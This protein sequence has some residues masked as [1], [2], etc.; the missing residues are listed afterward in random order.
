MSRAIVANF[1]VD[2]DYS[3]DMLREP[4][5]AEY[6]LRMFPDLSA[7]VATTQ[8]GRGQ[9]SGVD[10]ILIFKS[11]LQLTV[12]E[13]VRR[14]EW[15]DILLEEV[16]NVERNIVGWTL[17]PH[18]ICDYIAYAVPKLAVC[19][20]I[21][22]PLLRIT[23]AH[24]LAEWTGLAKK[25]NPKFSP[26]DTDGHKWTTRNIAVDWSVLHAAMGRQMMRRY[27]GD[28]VM[29]IPKAA[30]RETTTNQYVFDYRKGSAL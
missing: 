16:W 8:D 12:D 14:E 18:K 22:Y 17:D 19:Y 13:K 21:P 5:W 9:R 23:F 27:G 4:V 28:M 15:P 29:P 7:S 3:A 2:L 10:R 26:N 20:F 6:Y 1:D 11:G 25:H 24:H 30:E